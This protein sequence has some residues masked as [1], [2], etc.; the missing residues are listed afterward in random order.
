MVTPRPR[1]HRRSRLATA[2]AIATALLAA[3]CLHA[4]AA[5]AAGTRA[6]SVTWSC[7][8]TS[9]NAGSSTTCKVS[10]ADTDS[11]TK[12]DPDGTIAFSTTSGT[13][14]SGSVRFSAASCTLAA[15]AGN[16]TSCS[17]TVRPIGAGSPVMVAAYTASDDHQ[18]SSA[19]RSLTVSSNS[20]PVI[21]PSVSLATTA[22]VIGATFDITMASCT[23]GT[24]PEFGLWV[25]QTG[26]PQTVSDE[27][28]PW[29][30]AVSSWGS[31]IYQPTIPADNSTGSFSVRYYCADGTPTDA[32]D[33]KIKWS[34]SLYTFSV[35][36][37]STAGALAAAPAPGS[38]GVAGA[39]ASVG[40]WSV[41]PD[42]LPAV[43][44]IGIPG[45]QAAALK[46]RVDAIA[47]PS[48]QV[49]RL[50]TAAL[51]RQADRAFMD[52]WVP[53]VATKGTYSLE[54]ALEAT[55]EFFGTFA[56]A[57]EDLFIQ[58]A[59]ERVV[60]RWPTTAERA[61]AQQV[62]RTGTVP[63]IAFLRSLV[64]APDRRA[65]TANRDYVAAIYQALTKVVPSSADLGRFTSLLN[66]VVVR[67]SVVEE[68]ALSRATA[69]QWVAAMASPTGSTV[70]F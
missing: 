63:R 57:T 23:S 43:D 50:A 21:V 48:G 5:G 16:K 65:A 29:R 22:G 12:N 19:N 4:P 18:D 7:T 15:D 69:A 53:V 67:V 37:A 39:A 25:S 36:A 70:R 32:G 55:P 54:R 45:A 58:R 1:T 27:F 44:N 31:A 28:R 38:A 24:A 61:A 3:L 10:V 52:K 66:D 6:V 8:S 26:D 60:G 46:A 49:T 35:S 41:D 62:L 51:G 20:S 47:G 34:S 40:T 64:E 9:L 2:A 33:A 59:Y 14:L 17:V 68:V 13:S 42:S 11:G 30:A 56:F